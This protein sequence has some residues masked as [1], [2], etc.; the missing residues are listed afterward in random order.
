MSASDVEAFVAR[1]RRACWRRCPRTSARGRQR[2]GHRFD[3]PAH[4]ADPGVWCS[5]PVPAATGASRSRTSSSRGARLRP[6][7][8]RH[9]AG[10]ADQHIESLMRTETLSNPRCTPSAAQARPERAAVGCRR[11]DG[12]T[13][14]AGAPRGLDPAR[15]R[16]LP[17]DPYL[18]VM[19]RVSGR[20]V[21][22]DAGLEPLLRLLGAPAATVPAELRRGWNACVACCA[23]ARSAWSAASAASTR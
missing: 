18:L 12:R 23:S 20:W 13:G 22:L 19:D 11:R 7:G 9:R 14:D 17:R 5:G 21:T 3:R 10:V 2:G 1:R 4:A 6:R 8:G 15:L 16:L